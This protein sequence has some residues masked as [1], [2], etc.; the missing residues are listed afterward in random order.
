MLVYATTASPRH[1]YNYHKYARLKL[2]WCADP[3]SVHF[4]WWSRWDSKFTL[5]PLAYQRISFSLCLKSSNHSTNSFQYRHHF[6]L[7]ETIHIPGIWWTYL[8]ERNSV[9][10]NVITSDWLQSCKTENRRRRTLPRRER[11]ESSDRHVRNLNAGT[12]TIYD[13]N[14]IFLMNRNKLILIL[15]WECNRPNHVMHML[16]A[17][18]LIDLLIFIHCNCIRRKIGNRKP[19]TF[20]AT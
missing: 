10:L 12:A 17:V 5:K 9:I 11:A 15:Y 3:R 13:R 8:K 14:C 6:F 2:S 19:Q 16:N 7:T 4:Q 18:T 20:N 1:N